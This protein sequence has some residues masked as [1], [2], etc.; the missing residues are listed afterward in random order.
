VSIFR[1][2][3]PEENTKKPNTTEPAEGVENDTEAS[4]EEYT[5]IN[6]VARTASAEEN[7]DD[8]M[9]EIYS[10]SAKRIKYKNLTP[11]E[12]DAASKRKAAAKKELINGK[13]EFSFEEDPSAPE[14]ELKAE[15][16]PSA[17]V[18]DEIIEDVREVRSLRNVYVQD[19]DDIDISLDPMDSVREYERRANDTE[20]Q[21]ARK[22]APEEQENPYV[23]R[24]EKIVAHVPVY[25][26]DSKV[27]KIYLKAGRFTEVVESEY[28]EYLKSTDPTISKNYHAMQRQIHPKQSL[29]LTL[30]QMAQKRQAEAE[31]QKKQPETVVRE[32]FDEEIEP[33]KKKQSKLGK[34][35]RVVGAL[36]VDSF[37]APPADDDGQSHDYNSRE[38]EK[39]VLGKIG[40]ELKKLAIRS[41]VFAVSFAAL[42]TMNILERTGVFNESNALL[43]CGV[44]LAV[45]VACGVVG[46]R[47]IADGLR[48]LKH[49]KGNSNTPA[50]LAVCA[51]VIQGIVSM[52][53]CDGFVGGAHHL[54]GYIA[55]LALLLNTLGRLMMTLRVKRN[56]SFITAHS[57]AYAAKI[58]ND[59]E[60]ARRMVSGTTASKG[61]AAYQHLT[62]FLSDF[63][64]ISYAPDP[65][66]EISG[67][68]V[69]VSVIVSVFVTAVYA[70][71]F[72]SVPGAASALTVMLC[73]S[74]PFTAM[75]AGNLPMMFF[76]KRMLKEGAMVAGYPSVKQFCDTTAVML[77]ASELFPK[78]SVKLE[79]MTT[80]Q[81]YRVE[82]SL[83]MAAAVL[84]EAASPIAP[85][86]DELI[87]E[88]ESELPAVES[89][90]FEEKSGLVGWI[91]GERVL[92]GNIA[93]MNR[94]HINFPEE[95][96]A[97][98]SRNK[99]TELTYI[100]CSG[101]P[102]AVLSLS[103]SAPRSARE[104]LQKA[105]NSGLA[106]VV[107][108]P[109]PNVSADMIAEEY[110]LFFRSVKIMSPGYANEIEE[111]TSKVEETSRAYLATRG[112]Q[113]S[114]ARAVGGCI[115]LKSNITLGIAIAI[116][117]LVLGI[118]LCATLALY[119][120]V[121]RLSV[122]EMMIYIAF[123]TAATLI[124]EIIRRP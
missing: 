95:R 65:S 106:F 23:R 13:L 27:E 68:I 99:K 10:T 39:Y 38:D 75:L 55:A 48:P 43:Y 59:E 100:A 19:I 114:L 116:F 30:S 37:V 107:S 93:L 87:A 47:Y 85:V 84:R 122:V 119:A 79:D 66:E 108:S 71:L 69:P 8:E 58:Y 81:Q 51:C 124:S 109:D 67:K 21:E 40:E 25:R 98:R 70:V 112:R 92:I 54:Y 88:S 49:F 53:T 91:G 90:M 11:I 62:R 15:L 14:V 77:T 86:F 35:F 89:V 72:K 41:A 80:L 4:E 32:N 33:P 118:L 18:A 28:D 31:Q 113:S 52:F 50:A 20:R 24:G 45:T 1:K 105:E 96:P 3:K 97:K 22:A 2:D 104:Q 16:D 73:I 6:E 42:L 94:Y 34:F 46:R 102:V 121:S 64:K 78:G 110:G 111:V 74:V 44:F 60:T 9:E 57:P 76:S 26:H 29:L 103:Y 117:G 123:W 115:G 63:L 120:S 83:L 5:D 7:A 12:F 36:I 17:V 82:E 101:S 61:V 56:F